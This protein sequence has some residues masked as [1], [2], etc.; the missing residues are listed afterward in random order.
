MQKVDRSDVA[1][2]SKMYTSKMS[3]FFAEEGRQDLADIYVRNQTN[4]TACVEAW[5][6][7]MRQ[8]FVAFLS[9]AE[10]VVSAA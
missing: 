3:E 10:P 9:T 5:E 7:K 1:A 2:L 8:S 6:N 4:T